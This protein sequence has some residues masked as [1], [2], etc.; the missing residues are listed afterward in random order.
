MKRTSFVLFLI[1][2]Y[3]ETKSG[4]DETKIYQNSWK[5]FFY[6]DETWLLLFIIQLYLVIFS[7]FQ[8]S[9]SY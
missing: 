2:F 3:G 4:H 1:F 8:V 5:R 7:S 6:F 9:Y